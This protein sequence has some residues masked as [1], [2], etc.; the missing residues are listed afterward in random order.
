MAPAPDIARQLARDLASEVGF[1]FLSEELG[2]D[3][4]S[5]LTKALAEGVVFEEDVDALSL[6]RNAL[7]GAIIA[8]QK[9]PRDQL[10]RDFLLNGP[11]EK[12]G[13]IPPEMS[14]CRLSD[15]QTAAAVTLIFSYMVN[16]FKGAI[17]ELLAVAP[18][19]GVMKRLK[20]KSVLPMD[21]RLY[22]GDSVRSRRLRGASFAKGADMHILLLEHPQ[23]PTPGVTV[24]GVAEV[25]SYLTSNAKLQ[26]QIDKHVR[27]AGRGLEVKGVADPVAQPTIGIGRERRVVRLTVLPDKWRLPRTIRFEPSKSG[28]RLIVDSPA[29]PQPNGQIE[30]VGDDCW[31][32]TLRWSE[33]ALES[34][35]HEMTFWYMERV[36]E[37]IYANNVP[38][39][40]SEMSPA[41]AGRN[42]AKE[43]LYY[44]IL[45]FR[46]GSPQEQRAIALYNSYGFGYALGTSF[47]DAD[48]RR[49]MLWPQDLDEIVA[50]GQ[51]KNG[52]RIV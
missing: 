35:A 9:P 33:E 16:C 34:I 41:E 26:S 44:A 45:R 11:Y 3:L 42:A 38:K 14:A 6:Y 19:L 4:E 27:R 47:R 7:A 8:I 30:Q 29:P 36:G 31:R 24:A 40:W 13:P 48:G 28:R 46:V 39:E 15:E 32:I 50:N 2:A 18:C 10:F 22:A 1:D 20:D 5:S 51:T 49:Q 23:A 52:C 43:K 25:K 37:Q 12:D 17:A 21:A